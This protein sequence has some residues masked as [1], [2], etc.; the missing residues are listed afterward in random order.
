MKIY[1]NLVAAVTSGLNEVLLLGKQADMVVE[2]L[3]SSNRKWGGRDRKFVADNIYTIVR[4][5]RLYEYCSDANTNDANYTLK[6]LVAKLLVHDNAEPFDLMQQTA[7]DK[8]AVYVQYEQA[9]STRK[10]IESIPDWLDELGEHEIGKNWGNEIHALNDAA[11]L[12]IRINTLKA[13]K[14]QVKAL[15]DKEGVEYCDVANAPDALVINT[16][17]NFKSHD[18]YKNGWFEI[19]DVSSQ[20]VAPVLAAESGMTVIDAC[21]GGG[22]KTLHTAAMMHNKGRVIAM[23][24]AERKLKNLQ[25]RATRAGV[26]IIETQLAH[27]ENIA[28]LKQV[29]DRLLLDVPCSGLGVLRRKPDAKWQLSPSFLLE[30]QQLQ[31]RILDTYTSMLKPGGILVYSTCSILPAENEKQVQQFLQKHSG[32]FTLVAEEKISPAESGFDGFYM[33]KLVKG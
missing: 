13:S 32:Q 22:G 31:H 17:K 28:A 33:A 21:A 6:L 9:K 16:R 1:P 12:S 8:D 29:A 24:I 5:K 18:A 10:I 30:I 7:L 11:K 19:Q 27:D 26:G 25:Q 15:F 4:Y 20:H 2:H 14:A 23:D 3:L